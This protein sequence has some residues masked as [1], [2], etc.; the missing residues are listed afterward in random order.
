MFLE[1][2]IPFDSDLA[3]RVLGFLLVIDLILLPFLLLLNLD[4]LRSYSWIILFEGFCCIVPRCT[5]L[6]SSA[7]S[8]IQVEDQK[9]IG[10]GLWKREI[11]SVELSTEQIEAMR[12]KGVTMLIIGVLFV[13]FQIALMVV[14]SFLFGK[15]L[16]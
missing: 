12:M 1:M 2:T 14:Y 11:R 13:S 6:I 16:I 8:T 15:I 5:Q 4:L 9:Y 7:S 10:N 3:F